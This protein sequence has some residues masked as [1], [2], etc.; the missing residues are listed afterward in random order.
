MIAGRLVKVVGVALVVCL[1]TALAAA[2]QI[3][4]GSMTG[5]VKD[6]Q[7]GVIPGATVTLVSETSGTKSPPIVTTETGDFLFVNVA[8]GHLH[9]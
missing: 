4:T 1:R 7:G 5:T 8:T 9:G 2:A 6:A 3:T